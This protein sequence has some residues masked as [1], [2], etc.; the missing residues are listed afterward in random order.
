M[1]SDLLPLTVVNVSYPFN[2]IGDDSVGGAE[3]ML[4]RM[5]EA[6][7][8]GGHRSIVLA[9]EGSQC[10][11]TLVPIPT[12]PP[13]APIDDAATARAHAA[14]RA[15][16]DETVRNEHVDVLH[17]HGIDFG[18]V[19]PADGPA[20]VVTIHLPP[21]W[22][23]RDVLARGARRAQ[24]VCVSQAQRAA[25]ATLGIDALVIG[26]GV[27]IRP[28]PRE[29]RFPD[30]VVAMGRIC[31]EKGFHH[32]I[33]AARLAGAALVLAGRVY[34]FESHVRYFEEAIVPRLDETR[35]FLGPLDTE[36]RRRWLTRATCLLVPSL[37]A[38]TSSLVAMEA[39]ACGTPVV[40]FRSGALVEI[41]EHGKTGFLVSSP[42]E[43]AHAIVAARDLDPE[44]CLR[45]A[46][47]RFDVRRTAAET[48]ALYRVVAQRTKERAA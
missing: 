47:E 48:L 7:V 12:P 13:G 45:A 18:E 8:E 26:N 38:E 44:D 23:A 22:Y 41:V 17:F 46:R 42:D 35:R 27:R 39:L 9:A 19:L 4:A 33:D 14:M 21:D 6:L 37:V 15:A 1:P 16:L 5:D 36:A 20:A 31:P 34:P 3:Q 11:G 28:P 30:L 25:A 40:A 29:P 24:L 10:R 43:M 2:P 32:A